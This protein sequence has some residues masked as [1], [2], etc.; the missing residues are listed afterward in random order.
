MAMARHASTRK[1]REAQEHGAA[2]AS[3]WEWVVAALG[4]ALLAAAIGYLVYFAVTTAAGPPA[5]VFER[6]PVARSGD[7]Y[8]VG[9]VIRNEGASTASA[10]EIEGTLM[11][12]GVTV[13][14]STATLDYLPRFSSRRAGLF[15]ASDP[16]DGTLQLRANGYSEP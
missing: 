3:P 15:F 5:V 2:G 12:N 11:R 10:V 6:G 1:L 7:G 13:E 4:L 9:V 16:R 8:V 14:T